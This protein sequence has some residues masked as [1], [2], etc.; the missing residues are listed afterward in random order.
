MFFSPFYTLSANGISSIAFENFYVPTITAQGIMPHY[1]DRFVVP[2]FGVGALP[3]GFGINML[4]KAKEHVKSY[5]N[6]YGMPSHAM[7]PA[8]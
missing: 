7:A 4:D 2:T 6:S 3:T 1:I 5:A 8:H